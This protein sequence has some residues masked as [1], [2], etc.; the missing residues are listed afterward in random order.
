MLTLG[1]ADA[2]LGRS[3]VA[4]QQFKLKRALEDATS[5]HGLFRSLGDRNGQVRA[6][7]N[8][9]VILRFCGSYLKSIERCDEL[10]ASERESDDRTAVANALFHRGAAL[11]LIGGNEAELRALDD[12]TNAFEIHRVTGPSRWLSLTA[13]ILGE[14]RLARNELDEAEAMLTE[15]LS[16]AKDANN[17]VF[18]WAA[19]VALAELDR[20]RFVAV[21]EDQRDRGPLDKAIATLDEAIEALKAEDDPL[22]LGWAYLRSGVAELAVGSPQKAQQPLVKAIETL[23]GSEDSFAEPHGVAC[24]LALLAHT[25]ESDAAALLTG[26]A[27]CLHSID[28]ALGRA[29]RELHRAWWSELKRRLSNADDIASRGRELLAPRSSERRPDAARG[30]PDAVLAV[31]AGRQFASFRPNDSRPRAKRV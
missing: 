25:L 15:S 21:P 19:I 5:A 11:R 29:D 8:E 7:T 27:S 6:T 28:T 13:R 2:L 16:A 22:E 30:V 24:A 18:Q 31:L 26:T 3:Y 10:L 1:Y 23:S 20:L 17:A 14:V 12:L 9:A 4:R